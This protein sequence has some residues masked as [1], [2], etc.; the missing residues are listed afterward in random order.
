MRVEVTIK[1]GDRVFDAASDR[2]RTKDQALSAL[3]EIYA[4]AMRR[5]SQADIRPEREGVKP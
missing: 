5:V 3:R 1:I 2:P 4:H